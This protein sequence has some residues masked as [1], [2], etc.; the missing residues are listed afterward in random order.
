VKTK[1]SAIRALQKKG[2]RVVTTKKAP[3]KKAPEKAKMPGKDV[4]LDDI[5]GAVEH[6]L[7]VVGVLV[8][9]SSAP[10]V[11]NKKKSW[12]LEVKRNRGGFIDNIMVKEK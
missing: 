7:Q 3:A 2:Y 1:G 9:K 8:A 10:P 5:H 12:N 4:R 11:L 6:L